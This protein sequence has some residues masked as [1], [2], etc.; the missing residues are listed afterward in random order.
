M[1]GFNAKVVLAVVLFAL[2]SNVGSFVTGNLRGH[3]KGKADAEAACLIEKQKLAIDILEQ[4]KA[5]MQEMLDSAKAVEESILNSASNLRALN[6]R[7]LEA[8]KN[9]TFSSN[10]DCRLSDDELRQLVRAYTI[11]DRGTAGDTVSSG[12]SGEARPADQS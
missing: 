3:A 6:K 5:K 2:V 1:F 11:R 4:E 10:P 9:A 12:T 7:I 8:S